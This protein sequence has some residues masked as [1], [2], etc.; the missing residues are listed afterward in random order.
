M[1]Y[2]TDMSEN[3]YEKKYLLS[4]VAKC[5]FENTPIQLS[6]LSSHSVPKTCN[7]KF[8]PTNLKCSHQPTFEQSLLL[9][10]RNE[11]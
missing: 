8:I 4:D 11:V 3:N 10:R 6:M 2:V 1:E 7:Y 9:V 5:N